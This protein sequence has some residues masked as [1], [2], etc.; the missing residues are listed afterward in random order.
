MCHLDINDETLSDTGIDPEKAI[1]WHLCFSGST[2]DNKGSQCDALKL[3]EKAPFYSYE[4]NTIFKPRR[5]IYSEETTSECFPPRPL[6]RNPTVNH[7]HLCA[8]C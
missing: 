3:L 6:K 2:N 8:V 1:A 7:C 4:G 5:P